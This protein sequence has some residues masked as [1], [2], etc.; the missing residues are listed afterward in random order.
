MVIKIWKVF[1]KTFS[2]FF[3][4][5]VFKL[6]A[7]LS[8]YTAFSIGPLLLILISLIGLFFGGREAAQDR[9]LN[10]IEGLIGAKV[11]DQLDEILNAFSNQNESFVG[12]ITGS[13]VLLLGATSV[14][15]DMQDSMNRLWNVKPEQGNRWWLRILISR[16]LSFSL[17]VSMG[18]LLLVSLS[19]SAVLD[20]FSARLQLYFEDRFV[21]VFF[22]LNYL[23][24][25]AITSSLF[26]AIFK[27]LP[28]AV[29][30]SKDAIVGSVFTALLFMLGKFLITVYIT[31]SSFTI[32]YGAAASIIILLAWVYYSSAILYLGAI[33]TIQYAH[34]VG[35]GVH[36]KK[37]AT[38]IE[39]E[40]IPK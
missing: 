39:E 30:K 38:M 33:F 37:H 17:V 29:I 21:V 26:F 23:I 36:P 25:I 40:I 4:A 28:D 12:I 27:V 14:F 13:I 10:Q 6:C 2:Q 18:F 3:D 9:L 11:V 20:S 19:V 24:V 7:S 8:Y 35:K 31:Q 5:N 22:I 34:I 32:T 1:K 16:L 15:M